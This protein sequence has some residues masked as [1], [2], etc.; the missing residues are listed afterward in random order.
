M[1][2][3]TEE[4]QQVKFITEG[5]GSGKKCIL[6]VFSFKETFATVMEEC[7]LWKLFPVK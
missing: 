7:I 6:K 5:K 4:V 3:I 1:K 2:L